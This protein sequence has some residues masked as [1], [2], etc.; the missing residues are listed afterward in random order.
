MNY[1]VHFLKYN[2]RIVMCL[3]PDLNK[4]PSERQLFILK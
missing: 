4:P 2:K 3:D 1:T